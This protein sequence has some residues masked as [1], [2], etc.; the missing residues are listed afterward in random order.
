MSGGGGVVQGRME[1]YM[2]RWQGGRAGPGA[3]SHRRGSN[4][5]ENGCMLAMMGAVEYMNGTEKIM[6]KEAKKERLFGK[7]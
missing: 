5:R 1:G 2:K 6:W 3:G 7:G 4:G